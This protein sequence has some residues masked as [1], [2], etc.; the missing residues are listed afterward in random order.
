MSVETIVVLC[1]ISG[2]LLVDKYSFGEF[3]ISQPLVSASILGFACGDFAA[4]VLLG[5]LLQPIWLIELPIGRKVPLDAQAAG[6][7]GAVTFFTLRIAA[8]VSVETGAFVSLLVA[9]LASLWGGWFDF[10]GRRINGVLAGRIE[11]VRSLRELLVIHIAALDIAFLRGVMV[12]AVSIGIA[13]LILPIVMLDL[14]PHIP[15][16][17]LLAATLSIGLAGG[18]VLFGSKKRWIPVAAGF[19]SWVVVWLLVRF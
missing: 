9:A 6:I 3:G 12:A 11:R 4:G 17:R 19:A 15:L 13:Y 8:S 5:V 2:V 10:L 16:T 7:S 18:L 1:L 14:L